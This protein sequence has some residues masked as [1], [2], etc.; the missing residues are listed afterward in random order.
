MSTIELAP[1]GWK[2]TFNRMHAPLHTGRSRSRT[3]VQSANISDILPPEVLLKMCKFLGPQ[4]LCHL[5]RTCAQMRELVAHEHKLWSLAF[6]KNWPKTHKALLIPPVRWNFDSIESKVFVYLMS[7]NDAKELKKKKSAFSFKIW[8][9]SKSESANHNNDLALPTTNN[10]IKVVADAFSSNW[11]T[12][13]LALRMKL[14]K[15]NLA[16]QKAAC[17]VIR[18]L[19]YYSDETPK[20]ERREVESNV[21]IFGKHKVVKVIS[22]CLK[23]FSHDTEYLAWAFCALG[24]LST[25]LNKNA[26]CFMKHG[27]IETTLRL[28]KKNYTN[29]DV[30]YYGCFLL[31]NLAV[32]SM[33]KWKTYEQ[34]IV[35]RKGIN[36]ILFIMEKNMDNVKVLRRCLSVLWVLTKDYRYIVPDRKLPKAMIKMALYVFEHHADKPKVIINVFQCLRNLAELSEESHKHLMDPVIKNHILKMLDTHKKHLNLSLEGQMLLFSMYIRLK[37]E[38]LQGEGQDLLFGIADDIIKQMKDHPNHVV[39]NQFGIELL[40]NFTLRGGNLLDH[41]RGQGVGQLLSRAMRN[42]KLAFVEEPSWKLKIKYIVAHQD[43]HEA[44]EIDFDNV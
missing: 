9:Q 16:F 4:E 21:F 22:S 36:T 20:E 3:E 44:Q 13:E 33:R 29:E 24:N 27:G 34:I 43:D 11:E 5:A 17:Y 1:S 25:D 28:M 30:V 12:E 35:D 39:V 18:R 26:I 31:K 41:I 10:G 7:T 42:K 2:E 19:C 23:K 14:H 40:A 15:N 8:G 38:E 32:V 6:Q 37:P